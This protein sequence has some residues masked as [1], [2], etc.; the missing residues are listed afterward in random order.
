MKTRAVITS[1][2]LRAAVL[3]C[4]VALVCGTIAGGRVALATSPPEMVTI[5]EIAPVTLQPGDTVEV[6]I[7]VVIA[8]G[9]HIQANPASNEFLIP[10]E[11]RLDPPEGL[12]I[13]AVQYP[14]AVR[15]RLQGTT[16]D[17]LTCRGSVVVTIRIAAAPSAAAGAHE[18]AGALGYQACDSRTCLFPTSVPIV[19]P[20]VVAAA[21][22]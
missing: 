19:I 11:V 9:Y 5:G 6:E 18:L 8:G 21:P 2:R 4:S 13:A 12:H 16:E 3:V 20:V 14:E 1:A 22:E 17:L 7:P 10:M 15:Y